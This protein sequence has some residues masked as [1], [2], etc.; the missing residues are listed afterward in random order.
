MNDLIQLLGPGILLAAPIMYAAIGGLFTQRAGIFN[1]A[2]EGFMLLSA[3]F[4]VLGSLTTGSLWTGT[5]IGVGASLTASFLMAVIVVGFGA[6]EVIVGIA[7]NLLALGLTTFLLSD[8]Q[9]RGTRLELPDG[10][11][12]LHIA[13]IEGLP[14]I[15]PLFNDRDLLIWALIPVVIGVLYV[16]RHTAFGLQLKAAGEAPLAARA[17]G[18]RVVAVRFTSILISGFFCGVA[19]AELAIGSVHLFSENM[20][21]GRGIVAFAAV[22]FGAGLVGRVALACVLFGFAQAL[23]GLL[24]IRTDFPPQFVLM[25]PFLL[26]ILAVTTSD[27]L[28]GNRL[29][30][31]RP[32]VTVVQEALEAESSTLTVVGHLTIDEVRL[33]DGRVLPGTLGGAA[34]YAAAGVFLA[35]GRVL[36]VSRVG[37]DYPLSRLQLD[38]PD[39]GSVET[40]HVAVVPHRSVHNVAHYSLDGT[41]RFDIE[42]FDVMVDQT[43]SADDVRHLSLAG[44]WVL[45][46]P[47]TLDQQRELVEALRVQGAKVALD[48]EL[49]YFT[50]DDALDRLRALARSVDCFLPSREHLVHFFG[51]RVSGPAEMEELIS[52]FNCR[53]VV[54]KCGADGVRVFDPDANSAVHVPAVPDI[55]V[56]DPTGAGDA[57]N[58]GF[59][60]ALARGEAPIHAAVSGCVAASFVVETIGV[61]VPP[62][63]SRKE[64]SRRHS[65]LSA[66]HRTLRPSHRDEQR[67]IS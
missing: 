49:H 33:P 66:R 10:Y 50:D 55:E 15:D 57:F 64:W 34:G 1:I 59:L 45:V 13:A 11:E 36:V 32:E 58:G 56:V 47:A 3:Y 48:T 24:Q 40:Q 7:V 51:D 22:I 29:L 42:D 53:L 19:G 23:A 63:F 65:G 67:V 37:E 43:P 31:R 17:A 52:S 35:Q 41:R 2:L 46:A 39:G 14:V 26:T 18:V 4:S 61:G 16:F 6:D 20:T 44:R 9:R 38:H 60:V 25:A 21:S 30:R 62:G 28:R 8:A 27:A 12:A 5:M 54:V